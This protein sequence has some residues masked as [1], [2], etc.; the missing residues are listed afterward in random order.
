MKENNLSAEIDLVGLITV[1]KNSSENNH[2]NIG[3]HRTD[4]QTNER[5]KLIVD[6]VCIVCGQYNVSILRKIDPFYHFNPFLFGEVTK[7]RLL[8]KHIVAKM[9]FIY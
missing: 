9:M 6:A 8:K 5:T 2:K 4:E 7:N 1:T 3:K